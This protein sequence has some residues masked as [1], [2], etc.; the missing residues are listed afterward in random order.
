MRTHRPKDLSPTKY[1]IGASSN[2]PT[3]SHEAPQAMLKN[4]C[5]DIPITTAFLQPTPF[6]IL[7]AL[8]SYK[9]NFSLIMIN[10]LKY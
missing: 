3:I 5:S 9:P 7:L 2:V 8:C 1:S 10:Q 6:P 4:Q